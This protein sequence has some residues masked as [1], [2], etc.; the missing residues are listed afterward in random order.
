MVS[1]KYCA[2]RI[3]DSRSTEAVLGRSPLVLRSILLDTT[4]LGGL[5][6][7]TTGVGVAAL[8][9]L[10]M[11][12]GSV[13]NCQSLSRD[14]ISIGQLTIHRNRARRRL[15]CREFRPALDH[16]AGESVLNNVVV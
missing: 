7:L 16:R 2:E 8:G 15:A 5:V 10:N 6:V 9:A 4:V 12:V 11:G 13:A 3:G 1:T 14:E